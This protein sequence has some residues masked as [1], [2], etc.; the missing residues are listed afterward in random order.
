MWACKY[1]LKQNRSLTF[2][3]KGKKKS[4]LHY[5]NVV[6]GGFKFCLKEKKG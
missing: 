2:T 6:V 3:L 5:Q 4:L 1:F